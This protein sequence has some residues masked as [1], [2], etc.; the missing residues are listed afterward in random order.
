M[1][2]RFEAFT[3]LGGLAAARAALAVAARW[4]CSA[5]FF[6]RFLDSRIFQASTKAEAMKTE[7]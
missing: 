7:E 2:Y 4:A 3:L 6:T 1:L 5:C